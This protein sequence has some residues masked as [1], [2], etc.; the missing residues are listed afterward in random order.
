MKRLHSPPAPIESPDSPPAAAAPIESPDSP[1]SRRRKPVVTT[2]VYSMTQQ[3]TQ[4]RGRKPRNQDEYRERMVKEAE[5]KERERKAYEKLKQTQAELAA[6]KMKE[7]A[8]EQ[9]M[10]RQ[11]KLG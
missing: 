8:K 5:D 9:E 4:F 6:T 7:E 3:N 2:D 10:K 1:P 11:K